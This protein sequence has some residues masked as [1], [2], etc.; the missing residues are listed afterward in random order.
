[1]FELRS[2]PVYLAPG[3]LALAGWAAMAP[4][5]A[6]PLTLGWALAGTVAL[7]VVCVAMERAAR[8]AHAAAPIPEEAARV[9]AARVA[10]RRAASSEDSADPRR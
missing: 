4:A 5:S 8:P 2:A 10:A 6:Q 3:A 9:N 7:Y 1:M